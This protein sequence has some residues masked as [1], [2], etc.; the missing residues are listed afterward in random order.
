MEKLSLNPDDL[1]VTTFSTDQT[2]FANLVV[3]SYPDICTCIDICHSDDQ[4]T[5]W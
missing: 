2:Q 1:Q 3:E 5:S 4:H